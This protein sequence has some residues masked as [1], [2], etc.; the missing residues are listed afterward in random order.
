MYISKTA[1]IDTTYKPLLQLM[2]WER[3][4]KKHMKKNMNRTSEVTLNMSKKKIKNR[5]GLIRS[6]ITIRKIGT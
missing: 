2:T 3:I 5:K 6:L 4:M 1:T